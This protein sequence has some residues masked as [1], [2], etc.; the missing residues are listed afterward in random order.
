MRACAVENRRRAISIAVGGLTGG[1][2]KA[3][4]DLIRLRRAAR[5]R[6]RKNVIFDAEC[7]SCDYQAAASQ[8][9]SIIIALS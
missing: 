6:H 4:G 8:K 2:R 7:V 1:I 3:S 5:P 9:M